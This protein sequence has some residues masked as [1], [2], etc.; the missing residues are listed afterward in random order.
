[1]GLGADLVHSDIGRRTVTD[2]GLAATAIGTSPWWLS[3]DINH[4]AQTFVLWAAVVTAVVRLYGM[5]KDAWRGYK[6]G[7]AL[8]DD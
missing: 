7:K 2:L 5:A 6:I 1:M 4:W 3:A 8:D